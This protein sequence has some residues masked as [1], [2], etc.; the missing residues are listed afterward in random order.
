MFTFYY[1]IKNFLS[2]IVQP[3]INK[4]IIFLEEPKLYQFCFTSSSPN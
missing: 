2:P 3:K 1:V 4:T